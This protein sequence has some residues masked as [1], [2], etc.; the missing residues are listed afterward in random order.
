M[1][2]PVFEGQEERTW[3]AGLLNATII[4][5]ILIVGLGIIGNLIGGRIQTSVYIIEGMMFV[6]LLLLRCLLFTGRVT[7]TGLLLIILGMILVT[8][9]IASLGTI[10]TPGLSAYLLMVIIAGL[11]FGLKGLVLCT[12]S[13]S[14]AVLGLILAKNAGMLPAPDYYVN[15]TQ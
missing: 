15:I 6:F 14:L 8:A 4:V 5:S 3:R 10:C 9:D 7:L 13:S 12:V 2:P 1:A 11:L